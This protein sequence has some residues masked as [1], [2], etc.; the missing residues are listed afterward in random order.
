[1]RI[2]G[3][4]AAGLGLLVLALAAEPLG[5][6]TW[7]GL[8]L[9]RRIEA[10][11]WKIGPFR[12]Q[13]A[14]MIRNAGYDSNVYYRPE[15][16]ADYWLTAGPAF[17][18]Y[19]KLGKKIVVHAFESPQYV[20]FFETE[21]E[22]T[23]NNYFGADASLLLRRFFVTAGGAMNDARERWSSEVDYR[24]RRKEEARFGSLLWQVTRKTSLSVG[25]RKARYSY[26]NEVFEGV[27]FRERLNREEEHL[28][29]SA[30]FQ[31]SSRM[32]LFFEGE[33][34]IYDFDS[35]L[36]AGD[37]MSRAAY[38]GADFEPF[39]RVRG[40]IRLG[41]KAFEANEPGRPAFRGLVGDS[42]VSVRLLRVLTGRVSYRRDVRF[43]VFY[44]NPFFIEDRSGAGASLYVLRRK[45]RL[46][47]DYGRGRNSYPGASMSWEGRREDMFE[48]RTGGVYF[49]LAG[50]VGLGVT[51]GVLRRTID[52]YGWE[53]ER[54]FAALNLTYE[55]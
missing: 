38:A 37:S 55:F 1:M 19:V 36:S 33:Y 39:G 31:A 11:P 27:N 12:L 29:A 43:S 9:R 4:A 10:A 14:V 20:Y 28:T 3:W 17:D 18:A 26:E 34:G 5:A 8:E 22:R 25:L 24:P 13:P 40:R 30:F 42:A 48:T 41:Y 7:K 2:R 32:R 45:V 44:G 52:V 53:V 6:A 15:P 23:W 46:D 54:T 21:K 35:P 16:V 47:F 49:R 51:G 50:D